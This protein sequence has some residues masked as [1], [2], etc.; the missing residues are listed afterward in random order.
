MNNMATISTFT[1]PISTVARRLA[2]K[3]SRQQAT[4]EKSQ[5]VLLNTLSV[6]F[7][8]FYL[9]CIGFETDLEASDSWNVVQQTLMDVADLLI[10]N[11]GKLEC[12]PV[13][14]NAQFVYVPPEVQ[15][16]RIGYVAVQISE[17]LQS[18][19]LLGFVKE[20][21]IDNLPINQL[22]PLENLLDYLECLELQTTKYKSQ[23][24]GL[25]S[26]N[27]VNLKRWFENIFESGWSTIE[28]IFLTEPAWQF[29]SAESGFQNYVERA[30]LIDLGIT[31]NKASVGIVVKVSRDESN[32][33]EMKIIVELQPTNG[34]DYLPSSLH[35]MILDEEATAVM[36]AKAKNDNK[37][38]SLEFNAIVGDNFS[39]K[40]AL[41]DIS[42]IENF[43]I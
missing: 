25:S 7:V 24:L 6:S 36:E 30:K 8:N 17:S 11:I 9:E 19:K 4:P 13:L 21:S 33:D 31:A 41:E 10:K 43:V 5:Q 22:Q 3:W 12:R 23:N 38:I 35:V 27:V 2:E 34:Q 1:G 32:F 28:S 14:E 40:I 16:N 18:A 29:R 37:K 15:S 20:V 39:V 26:Q 42:V